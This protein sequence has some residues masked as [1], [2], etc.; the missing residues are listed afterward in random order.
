MIRTFLGLTPLNMPTSLLKKSLRSWIKCWKPRRRSFYNCKQSFNPTTYFQ[1]TITIP[2]TCTTYPKYSRKL[3]IDG[4]WL[5]HQGNKT[6]SCCTLLHVTVSWEMF[7]V[8][9]FLW[10]RQTMKLNAQI[11]VC[12][13]YTCHN[14][15]KNLNRKILHTK[16]STQKLPKLWYYHT[17]ISEIHWLTFFFHRQWVLLR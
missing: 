6:L 3:H 8:K 7:I 5:Q 16:N 17:H 4:P 9:I 15:Q 14:P 2:Y 12:L 1:L 10:G 13:Q 11:F